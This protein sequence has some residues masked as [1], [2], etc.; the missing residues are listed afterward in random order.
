MYIHITVVKHSIQDSGP[1]AAVPRASVQFALLQN[2]LNVKR[3]IP[4]QA[5]FEGFDMVVLLHPETPPTRQKNKK[6]GQGVFFYPKKCRRL[7]WEKRLLPRQ[8]NTRKKH[9]NFSSFWYGS[10]ER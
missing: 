6:K 3:I 7:T 5:A 10:A 8:R 4:T 1:R 9:E 2:K